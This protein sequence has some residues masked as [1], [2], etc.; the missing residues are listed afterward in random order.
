VRLYLEAR[1]HYIFGPSFTAADGR[2]RSADGQYVP[3]TLGIRF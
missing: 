2:K 3:I 1:Y